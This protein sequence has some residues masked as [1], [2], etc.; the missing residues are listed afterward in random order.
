MSSMMKM[1][2]KQ[3]LVLGP[4]PPGIHLELA[5]G[6]I[7]MSPSPSPDHSD[8]I[9]ALAGFLR[10]HIKQHKLGK[11]YADTDTVF[12]DEN[13]RRPDVIFFASA[14]L[15]LV[16]KKA[17]MGPP[18]LCVEVLSPTSVE[19]DR[20]DKFALYENR[21]V[22]NYWIVDPDAQVIEAYVLKAGKF[23]LAV[24]GKGHD[25]VRL[26]PFPELAIAL[27]EIWPES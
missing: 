1:T 24:R 2:S 14:R 27:A 16:G 10:P 3:Y 8:I 15:H 6:E 22:A 18:D 21:R 17:L 23:E 5:H 26:P 19:M 25:V 7:Y 9:L 20:E 13:T 12:D 11:L 4:D